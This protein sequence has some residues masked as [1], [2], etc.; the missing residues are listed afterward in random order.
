[1]AVL[2]STNGAAPPHPGEALNLAISEIGIS[3]SE[4]ARQSGITFQ[5]INGMIKGRR[6]VTVDS[7]L[8]IEQV[9]GLSAADLLTA[10]AA[11]DLYRTRLRIAKTL[12]KIKPYVA[13]KVA[14]AQQG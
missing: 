3:Q 13:P 7:A 1:M 8:R 10:Q 5:R 4:L 11:H 2:R 12:K 6:A 9:L 14:V